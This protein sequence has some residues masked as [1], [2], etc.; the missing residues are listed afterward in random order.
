MRR[1]D[2]IARVVVILLLLAAWSDGRAADFA[3]PTTDGWHGWTVEGRDKPLRIFVRMKGGS[4]TGMRLDN[5]H[6]YDN[7]PAEFND[8]GYVTNSKSIAWLKTVVA[9]DTR[10]RQEALFA[11]VM[12]DG[13]D[14]LDYFDAIFNAR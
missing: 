6:C 4:P 12:H 8:L 11:I 9:S 14:V 5:G 13:D 10:L 7:M 3:P 2:R 1:I